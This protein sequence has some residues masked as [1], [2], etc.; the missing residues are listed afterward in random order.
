[1]W[2]FNSM[3]K[4]SKSADCGG[5]QVFYVIVLGSVVILFCCDDYD[6]W[7]FYLCGCDFQEFAGIRIL[8]YIDIDLIPH[9]EYKTLCWYLIA[10][11]VRSH[12]TNGGNM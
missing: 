11:N 6:I 12:L 5:F 9:M 2:F 4:S 7:L 3:L 10:G 8:L 1:M